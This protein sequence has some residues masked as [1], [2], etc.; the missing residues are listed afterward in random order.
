MPQAISWCCF[1][2]VELAVSAVGQLT[3]PF[4]WFGDP[5]FLEWGV[6][7]P[8]VPLNPITGSCQAVAGG[9]HVIM[10]NAKQ[11]AWIGDEEKCAARHLFG[12]LAGCDW[13]FLYIADR[14]GL[15]R[16]EG[17]I[18]IESNAPQNISPTQPSA[19]ASCSLLAFQDAAPP[20]LLAPPLTSCVAMIP[21][22]M[23]E[24]STGVGE[25]ESW[26][27]AG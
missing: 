3:S 23:E 25:G 18:S 17:N 8:K 19:L 16:S 4:N 21:S 6:F 15:L 22:K 10:N 5:P 1:V 11:C 12:P 2:A 26:K 13:L 20:P 24:A 27:V 9:V 7:P 14:T